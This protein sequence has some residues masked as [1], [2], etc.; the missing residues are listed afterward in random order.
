MKTT[1][2]QKLFPRKILTEILPCLDKAGIILLAGARRTGKTSKNRSVLEEIHF[3]RTI[4]K[5][6]VDFIITEGSQITPVEVK[7]S[8]FSLPAIPS[9]IREF[10]K[11]HPVQR[12]FVLTKDYFGKNG[13]TI[14][15]PAWLC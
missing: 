10:Q 7:Y 9:G 14:F 8:S 13:N 2:T 3:W 15:L 11:N 6:E 5:N 12:S 1:A 4:S